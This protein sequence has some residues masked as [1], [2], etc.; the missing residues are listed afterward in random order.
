MPLPPCLPA[1]RL[2]ACW[3]TSR[4][5]LLQPLAPPA[6]Q[7]SPPPCRRPHLAE[8]L[9]AGQHGVVGAAHAAAALEQRVHHLAAAG[10]VL[11][12]G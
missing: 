7:G 10:D 11:L 6:L 5:S 2:L 4:P 9:S 12:R 1:G 8:V 3:N